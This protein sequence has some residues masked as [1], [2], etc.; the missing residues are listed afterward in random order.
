MNPG[1]SIA[2]DEVK[3]LR[4]EATATKRTWIY[5]FK[6]PVDGRMRQVKIG[7]WPAMGWINA[8]TRWQELKDLRASG[9][10]PAL[11]KKKLRRQA[12]EEAA[13]KVTTVAD[14]V[15]AYAKGHLA[16]NREPK[17]AVAVAQRLRRAT[18]PFASMPAAEVSRKMVFELMSSLAG[19]A[20]LAKSVKAELGAAWNIAM[21]AGLLPDETPNWWRQVSGP[22]MKSKG[23]MRD[24]VRKGTAKRVLSVPEVGTLLR[25]DIGLMSEAVRDVVLLYLWTCSRGV[26]LV[27]MHASQVTKEEDGVWWTLPKRLTKNRHIESATDHRVPLVGR[28]LE[29]V[30]RRM[31]KFQG[32]YLFP[33][34]TKQGVKTHLLQVNVGSPI[35]FRMPYSKSRPDITRERFQVTHW[36]PHDLRR[37]GRTLLA[38]LGCPNEIAEAIIGHVQPG[39][40]GTY[41]L[42]HYDKEKRH[43]LGLLSARL[44]EIASAV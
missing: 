26:E 32:G 42:Y 18:A 16:N 29:V 21:D 38:S 37:T 15:E 27:Q 23:A 35:H 34:T 24:G 19:T 7:E 1:E 13:I 10:D 17:G 30:N 22:K 40:V 31:E 5:R 33:R 3:G 14:V 41:N 2:F 12:E 11:D 6:S 20:V 44:E 43:W 28:A 4:L 8:V 9:V 25:E 39:I 36:S